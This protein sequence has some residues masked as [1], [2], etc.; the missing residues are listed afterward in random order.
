MAVQQTQVREVEATNDDLSVQITGTRGWFA[1]VHA[2]LWT[3]RELLIVGRD[4]GLGL[5]APGT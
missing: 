5:S 4:T 3:Y 1:L 2:D